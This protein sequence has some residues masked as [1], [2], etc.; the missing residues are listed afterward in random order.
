MLVR[1]EM[2]HRSSVAVPLSMLRPITS[3]YPC[4][5]SD[6][7]TACQATYY[8]ARQFETTADSAWPISHSQTIHSDGVVWCVRLLRTCL[9]KTCD[10]FFFFVNKKTL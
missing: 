3:L 5:V 8:T 9:N 1:L 10:S 2:T 6:L 7:V 4:R